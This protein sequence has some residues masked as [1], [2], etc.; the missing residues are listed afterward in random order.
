MKICVIL[1]LLLLL[2]NGSTCGLKWLKKHTKQQSS[3]SVYISSWIF[4]KCHGKIDLFLQAVF[5]SKVANIKTKSATTDFFSSPPFFLLAFCIFFLSFSFAIVIFRLGLKK[6][7]FGSFHSNGCKFFPK[8]QLDIYL[9]VFLFD[10]L[11]RKFL[12]VKKIWKVSC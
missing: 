6:P 1:L 4:W 12:K 11:H 9:Y 5:F 10:P 3:I 7:A 8:I 2:R